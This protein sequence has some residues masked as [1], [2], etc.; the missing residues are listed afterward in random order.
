MFRILAS[1]AILLVE[2]ALLFF[3]WKAWITSVRAELS[4][5]R[6]A[7]SCVALLLLSLNWCGGA[8]LA[9]FL[10]AYKDVSGVVALTEIMLVLSR[11]LD[12]IATIFA[13]SLKRASRVEAVVAGSLM[14]A[15]WPFGYA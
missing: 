14:L 3:A 2:L 10:F 11:P 13:I 6:N 7:L 5:W 1:V 9:A 15:G 12:A 8:L 4:Q